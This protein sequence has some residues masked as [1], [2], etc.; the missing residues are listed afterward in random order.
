MCA[1]KT[2][3]A[4][5][6]LGVSHCSAKSDCCRRGR[7]SVRFGSTAIGDIKK[8]EGAFGPLGVTNFQAKK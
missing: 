7:A 8:T 6:S 1:A 3:K 2:G 5:G 4:L